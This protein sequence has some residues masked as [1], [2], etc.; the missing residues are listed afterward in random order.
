MASVK[1]LPGVDLSKIPVGQPP[2][3]VTPNFVDPPSSLKLLTLILLPILMFM[4]IV[5]VATRLLFNLKSL[6]KLAK[7][8]SKA[9][10]QRLVCE[11]SN[12]FSRS[13]LHPRS[14][15]YY[16]KLRTYIFLYV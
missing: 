13:I 11:F 7:D 15:F 3:G 16:R 10:S 5:L 1:L 14:N 2:Q 8:D 6:R 4:M 9:N 12:S